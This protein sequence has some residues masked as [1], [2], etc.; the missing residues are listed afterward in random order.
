M[1]KTN[2]YAKGNSKPKRD[3]DNKKETGRTKSPGIILSVLFAMLPIYLQYFT[4]T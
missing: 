1:I 4:L 2:I 3:M